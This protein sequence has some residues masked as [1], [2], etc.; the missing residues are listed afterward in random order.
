[1]ILIAIGSNL[2]GAGRSPLATCEAALAALAT[3]GVTVMRRS[4]WYASD[5]QP[6]SG[7]PPFV[8]GVA[9]VTTTLAAPALLSALHV[10]EAQFG[11]V[12]DEPNAARTLDLDLLDYDGLVSDGPLVLPHPRM[13]V[14]SF[15]LV[16]L[17]ELAPNWRHPV[18]RRSAIELNAQITEDQGVRPLASSAAPPLSA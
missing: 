11:R 3:Q 4:R 12:R 2:A 9:E 13:G 5:A 6:P 14:R 10:V 18:N 17:A 1:M 7:Q 8:N 15:V 16:P